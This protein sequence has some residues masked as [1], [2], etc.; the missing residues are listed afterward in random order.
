MELLEE[1]EEE[2]RRQE[3]KELDSNLGLLDFL[4]ARDLS[5]KGKDVH[6]S[7]K[8]WKL[9]QT[10]SKSLVIPHSPS[11]KSSKNRRNS[12]GSDIYLT[13]NDDIDDPFSLLNS[14]VHDFDLL[15]NRSRTFINSGP[16]SKHEHD[17]NTNRLLRRRHIFLFSDVFLITIKKENSEN[18]ELQEIIWVKDMRLKYTDNN[19]N[20][21]E[22]TT[23]LLI[24]CKPRLRSQEIIL[25]LICDSESNKRTWVLDFENTMLA[26]QRD[27]P[28][29]MTLGWYHS[30]LQG[31]IYSAAYLN[32]VSQLRLF[33]KKNELKGISIDT[34]DKSGMNALHWAVFNGHEVCV[35][36]L[37]DH[38]A[39]VDVLQTGSNSPFLLAAAKGYESIGRIL[40]NRGAN[41]K[42]RNEKEKNSVL[43]SVLFGHS[44]KGLSWFLH[45]LNN[46]G[47]DLN[48]YDARGSAP[49]HVCAEKNLSGP[50]KVLV[51]AGANVNIVHKRNSLTPLQTACSHASPDVETIRAFL[52]KGAYPNWHDPQGRTAFDIVLHKQQSK[53][54]Y[55]STENSNAK[56]LNDALKDM[57]SLESSL[58]LNSNVSSNSLSSSNDIKDGKKWRSMENTIEKV[59][60]YAVKSL[61]VLLEIGKKG[62]RFDVKDLEIL[63][64]SFRLCIFEA[65]EVWE[66][67]IEPEKFVEFVLLRENSGE[68]I[69]LRKENWIKDK[70]STFCQLC[71]DTFGLTNRRHHCRRCG[72]ITCDNC[73]TKRLQ[74]SCLEDQSVSLSSRDK[75]KEE[76]QERVCDGC[77]NRLCYDSTQPSP[78]HYKVKQLKIC[79]TSLIER[80][81]DLVN[82]LDDLNGDPNNLQSSFRDTITR[83]LTSFSNNSSP[84]RNSRNSLSP[85][86]PNNRIG[87]GNKESPRKVSHQV[88]DA[89][90]L[91][92]LKLS[93]CEGLIPMFLEAAE[94]YQTISQ[95]LIANKISNEK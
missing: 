47:I 46:Y 11:L 20:E 37:L 14:T 7:A 9:V 38:G 58:I 30:I 84:Q 93:E 63:R 91:R 70:S 69:K 45:A 23:I 42:L 61:P 76:K 75:K 78:E 80:L 33:I 27:T 51:D 82:S 83:G 17:G 74:L 55:S 57:E 5:C 43:M 65:H 24:F 64:P 21:D 88:I 2:Q 95:K 22:S 35:R 29:S 71:T 54:S 34:P 85:N 67:K 36:V 10:I 72:V 13:H 79:A 56:S 48:E 44:T 77:Y 50:I 62:G 4:S 68:D 49:L 87:S 52:D 39:D 60:D 3:R 25:T 12:T 32:N 28:F 66:K 31:T 53:T 90:H 15:S 81:G 59:G 41:V 40:I 94:G 92:K 89:L 19:D 8:Q 18:Y 16:I 73:S 86:S 6:P 26:Y 1:I